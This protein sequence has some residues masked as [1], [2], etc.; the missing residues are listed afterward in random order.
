[1]TVSEPQPWVNH[2]EKMEFFD[3]LNF[4]LLE[5]KKVFFRFRIS[6]RPFFVLEYS[7]RH[8]PGLYCLTKIL[9]KMAILG[10]K[11]LVNPF[12]KISIFRLLQL[13]V[14][15]ANTGVFS[16]QNIVKDIS[17]PKLPKKQPFGK[18]AIFGPKPWVN[19]FGKMLNF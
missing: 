19:P 11:P 12:G 9:G 6:S 14:F 16:F 18:V 1:M 2:F 17:W 8:L 4:L 3:F 7:K 15:I 10:P 5:P 13:V